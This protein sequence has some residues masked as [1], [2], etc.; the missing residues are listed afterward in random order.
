VLLT[1]DKRLKQYD[2]LLAES[3]ALQSNADFWKEQN[4][5]NPMQKMKGALVD[6]QIAALSAGNI[7]TPPA[8]GAANAAASTLSWAA[9][10]LPQPGSAGEKRGE[11]MGKWSAGGA[12]VGAI[13]GIPGGPAGIAGGA[14]LG[15]AI[16]AE[17]GYLVGTFKILDDA[18]KG[19]SNALQ[20]LWK[21]GPGTGGR[22]GPSD[23]K[24]EKHSMNF[25]PPQKD[26]KPIMLSSTLNVDGRTLAE[27]VSEHLADLFTHP[28]SAPAA[29]GLAYCDTWR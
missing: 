17:V 20:F 7:L 11:E 15:G 19:A 8:V 26:Q 25:I 24:P 6:T 5:T 28:T 9:D 23:A 4:L 18:A 29:N 22:D 16:G 3:R 14:L 1:E 21:F 13:I 2:E 27:Q 12:G 10:Y